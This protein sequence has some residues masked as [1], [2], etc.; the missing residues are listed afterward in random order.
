MEQIISSLTQ[1]GSALKNSLASLLTEPD[2][3]CFFDIETTGLSPAISSV[4]LIGAAVWNNDEF[5]IVQWFA[6]DY[7][8]EKELL[9]SFSLFC[10]PFQA[11]VHYNGASFDIPYLEKKYTA[12]GLDSP[13]RDKESVDLF[14][15][16]PKDK[17]FFP[18]PDRKL[19]TMEK[20]LS[21]ERMDTFTGKDCIRLYTEFMHKKYFYDPQAKE[22]KDQLLRHN[23]DDIQ[24]TIFCAQLLSYRQGTIDTLSVERELLG[25]N[26]V[27]EGNSPA[28]N[29]PVAIIKGRLLRGYFPFP[30]SHTVQ[31]GTGVRCRYEGNCFRVQIPLFS[32]TLRHFFNDYKNYYYLPEEDTAVHKSVGTYVDKEHRR[33]ATA[34][35][36][37]VKKSGTFLAMPDGF[38]ADNI[39]LFS[40]KR[41]G[42]PAFMDTDT[43]SRLPQDKLSELLNAFLHSVTA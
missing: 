17:S 25:E 40:E 15:A 13:F 6:D 30:L 14:R 28:G 32:G 43:F 8:S 18:V 1:N 4:Y 33:Q 2:K 38:M 26:P 10:A 5:Q 37:Y 41:N 20:L 42:R 16:L 27:P 29:P 39:P 31:N 21:F 22:R 24:G 35:T 36:C 12:H 3:L 23:F 7:V 34:S 19:T 9:S 11:F